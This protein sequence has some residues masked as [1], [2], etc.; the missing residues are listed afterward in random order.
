M[1]LPWAD[2]LRA[3]VDTVPAISNARALSR[4]AWA[5]IEQHAYPELLLGPGAL[6]VVDGPPGAGKS[7]WACRLADAVRGPALLVSSEEGLGPTLTARLLR[8][9]VKRDDFHVVSRA[10]VDAAVELARKVGAVS[11]VLDSVQS[12]VW[13]SDELRHVLSVVDDLAVLIAVLQ[14]RKDNLPAGSNTFIHE[15]DVRVRVEDGRWALAK[16]R[17]QPLGDVGGGVLANDRTPIPPTEENL[18]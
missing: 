12:A 9:A 3:A 10:S 8:C 18:P 5:S 6:V 14:V 11:L 15:A 16:S 13:S 1:I 17:Y 7:S 4:Q 2:R